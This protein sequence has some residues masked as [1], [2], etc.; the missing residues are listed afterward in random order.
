MG[1]IMDNEDYM[2]HISWI[3][4]N[5]GYQTTHLSSIAK[6][7]SVL[8]DIKDALWAVSSNIASLERTLKEGENHGK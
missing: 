3:A 1:H 4:E 5:M 2:G 8:S 6:D 7:I